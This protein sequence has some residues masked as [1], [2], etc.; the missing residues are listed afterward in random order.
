MTMLLTLSKFSVPD[1]SP[2]LI[3]VLLSMELLELQTVTFNTF[4]LV[5]PVALL[6]F[7]DKMIAV[8]VV[9]RPILNITV[10]VDAGVIAR[11]KSSI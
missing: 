5:L 8:S 1:S 3:P 11:L 2:V 9:F 10:I 7:Y 6:K 4:P